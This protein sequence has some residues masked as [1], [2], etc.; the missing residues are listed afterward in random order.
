MAPTARAAAA[1]TLLVA[2]GAS[3]RQQIRDG[4]GRQAVHL[5]RALQAALAG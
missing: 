5:A 1:D 4:A 3:C 2:D